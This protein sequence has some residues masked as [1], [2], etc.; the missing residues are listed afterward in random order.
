MRDD[1]TPKVL[2]RSTF[3]GPN[4][5]IVWY[6]ADEREV[7]R[8]DILNVGVRLHEIEVRAPT[9]AHALELYRIVGL[10]TIDLALYLCA[11]SGAKTVVIEHL[12]TDLPCRETV[13]DSGLRND[14]AIPISQWI[15]CFDAVQQH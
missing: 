1:I 10:V 2:V 3:E 4:F 8:F 7:R 12:E 5:S 15:G 6:A 13:F 14:K 9:L 11:I